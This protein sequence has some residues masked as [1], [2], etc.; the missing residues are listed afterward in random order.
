MKELKATQLANFLTQLR[1]E[2]DGNNQ[3]IP[4]WIFA[5]NI[6]MTV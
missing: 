4:L 3:G 6:R 1:T 2:I 5:T